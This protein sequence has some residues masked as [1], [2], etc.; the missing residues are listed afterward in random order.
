MPDP[1][2]I[3]KNRLEEELQRAVEDE[4]YE[5]A[6]RLRDKINQLQ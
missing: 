5:E 1:A 3:E 2:E 6:A 4:N